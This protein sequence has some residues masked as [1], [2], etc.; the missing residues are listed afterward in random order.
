A[1]APWGNLPSKHPD[2]PLSYAGTA[3]VSAMAY[4]LGQSAQLPNLS[5]EVT[6][7]GSGIPNTSQPDADPGAVVYDALTNPRY[8]VGFPAS[9]I[10]FFGFAP[11]STYCMANGL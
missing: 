11:F 7:I 4:D 2:Q 5:Y 8:G 6:G 3:Y 9:R 10:P 1:Q